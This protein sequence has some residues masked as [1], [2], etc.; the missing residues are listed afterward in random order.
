MWDSGIDLFGQ[1]DN[2]MASSAAE[3]GLTAA[4][5][6]PR[7]LVSY[8]FNAGPGRPPEIV[9]QELFPYAKGGG[10]VT[11][12]P[13][14]QLLFGPPGMTITAG[15]Y[16]SSPEFF[17]YLVDQGLPETNPVA[18]VVSGEPAPEHAPAQTAPWGGIGVVVG[19][20]TLL[21]ATL[22]VRRRARYR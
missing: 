19:L 13:P 6:G 17:R 4:E 5:L 18:P 22:T 16:Q 11:Y 1:L 8:R 20:A 2:A 14:G 12:T 21:L 9:R 3:L 15:W 10:P 7:Y